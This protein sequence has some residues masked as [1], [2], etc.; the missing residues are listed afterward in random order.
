MVAIVAVTK[1]L[2]RDSHA[3]YCRFIVITPSHLRFDIW[4]N[5]K[6]CLLNVPNSNMMGKQSGIV[7]CL[8]RV[9]AMI[10]SD[11]YP[12]LR[13]NIDFERRVV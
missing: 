11:L 13:V 7:T 6:N 3:H 9:C 5:R 8:D 12:S 10:D 4:F 1:S 2:Q